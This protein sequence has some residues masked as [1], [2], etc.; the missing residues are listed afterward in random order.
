METLQETRNGL[1]V[2]TEWVYERLGLRS[3]TY[4]VPSYANAIPYL[5][6]GITLFGILIL[7]TTGIYLAQFYHPDR[8]LPTPASFTS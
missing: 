2:T 5:L 8:S 6:G 7:I 4:H 3:L 1:R